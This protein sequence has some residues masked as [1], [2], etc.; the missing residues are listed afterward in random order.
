MLGNTI[1]PPRLF[2]SFWLGGFESACHLNRCGQRLD[3]QAITHHD[4]QA[5]ED[6]ALLRSIGIRAARDSVRW[7]EIDRGAG[8]YDFTTLAP[9]VQA[10]RDHEVQVIWTLC[11]YGWPDDVDLYSAAFIERFAKFS[12]AVARYIAEQTDCV[13]FFCPINEISFFA[14]A[15]GHVAYIYPFHSGRAAEI[16]RQLVRAA[17]AS[18]EAIWDVDRRARIVHVDPLMHV[19]TPRRR[20]ELADA[21]IEQR[22]SQFESWD[23]LAGRHCPELGGGHKYLDI[24]GLNFY[25]ANQWE[26]PGD[27]PDD[28]LRWEDHPRDPRWVPLHRLLGEVF[29]RY[30]RPLFLSETSHFGVGRAPWLEEIAAEVCLARAAGTP[31]E[32]VCIY[33]ILDRPDWDNLEHWHNSGLW[34]LRS[35][36]NGRLERALINDYAAGVRRAQRMLSQHGCH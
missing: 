4:R 18:C 17:I 12:Q 15:A 27:G 30:E 14:W 9:L 35:D 31:V 22:N 8:R 33:P 3:M 24:M 2:K 25:H 28:R 7:R 10:A 20:P 6:Y 13:P 26:F 36:G 34:E 16:K 29:S 11:H 21:A 1:P 5:S 19:V 32:G 23:M